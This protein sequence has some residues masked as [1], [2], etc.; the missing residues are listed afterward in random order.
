MN[1]NIIQQSLKATN[2]RDLVLVGLVVEVENT[3]HDERDLVFEVVNNEA[4]ERF[5]RHGF[6]N[7]NGEQSTESRT[8]CDHCGHKVSYVCIIGGP[9]NRF[10]GI[11]RDCLVALDGL[12]QESLSAVNGASVK[13]V[14]AAKLQRQKA[15][16]AAQIASIAAQNAGFAEAYAAARKSSGIAGDIAD[17]IAR[18]GN[19]SEKQV[20]FLVRWH[21]ERIATQ[22]RVKAPLAAGKASITGRIVSAKFKKLAGFQ[23]GWEAKLALVVELESGHKV[24]AKI[25][26]G[27]PQDV[28]GD[29]R[30]FR[31][32]CPVPA[33]AGA[34]VSFNAT[35]ER[36][37]DATFAFA[38]R[39]TKLVIDG[40]KFEKPNA[41]NV[42]GGVVEGWATEA[43]RLQDER[44]SVVHAA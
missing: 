13:V 40:W 43:A 41:T 26:L 33:L 16:L 25:P 5:Q 28:C 29:E 27:H 14:K 21:A 7:P 38:K 35:I 34:T 15:A 39:V 23:G 18:W 9:D 4:Y 32:N 1:T 12:S 6:Y 37:D 20:A 36:S 11:G 24:Y 2:V 31:D 22:E 3:L 17:K 8:H 19:P 44:L 10:Y 30:W 42:S